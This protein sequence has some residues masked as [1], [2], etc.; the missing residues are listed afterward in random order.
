MF[1]RER[2]ELSSVSVSLDFDGS[3]GGKSPGIGNVVQA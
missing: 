1:V 2:V 3:I